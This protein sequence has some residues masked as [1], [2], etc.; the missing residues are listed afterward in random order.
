[1][2]EV[3][4]NTLF[5][6]KLPRIPKYLEGAGTN[7]TVLLGNCKIYKEEIEIRY[8]WLLPPESID[9]NIWVTY[10]IIVIDSYIG[11]V[12]LLQFEPQTIIGKST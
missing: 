4:I 8:S 3:I 9:S 10:P 6:V 11:Y 1:M 7:T 5:L 2:F 12:G